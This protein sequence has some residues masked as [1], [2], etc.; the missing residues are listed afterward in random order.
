MSVSELPMMFLYDGTHVA[1]HKNRVSLYGWDY[2]DI[3]LETQFRVH[4]FHLDI[5]HDDII[6]LN[7]EVA[8]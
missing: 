1:W 8:L 6:F 7:W 2:S 4:L 3:E 5:G